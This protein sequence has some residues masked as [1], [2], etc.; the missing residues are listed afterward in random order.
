MQAGLLPAEKTVISFTI[1]PVKPEKISGR[2]KIRR[3]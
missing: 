2:K 1:S 3:K